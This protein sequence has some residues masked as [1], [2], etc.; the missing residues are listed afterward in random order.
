V[1]HHLEVPC[2]LTIG[3][4]QRDER[5]GVQVLA[6]SFTAEKVRACTPGGNEYQTPLRINRDDRPRIGRAG[7]RASGAAPRIG[8]GLV[9]RWMR[10]PHPAQLAAAGVVCAHDAIG[11]VDALIVGDRRSHDHEIANDGR[12]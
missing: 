4:V 11:C 12:G 3:G 8:P 10:V 5:V 6:E 9:C 7:S 1:V 2:D